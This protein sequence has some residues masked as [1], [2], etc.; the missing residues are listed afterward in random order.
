[1]TG[2]PAT[3]NGIV[4]VTASDSTLYALRE[5]SGAKIWSFHVNG[6]FGLGYG[7]PVITQGR[8]FI[9][10]GDGALY[11]LSASSGSKIWSFAAGDA[12]SSPTIGQ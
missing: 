8:L 2:T 10:A 9:G 5:S 12:L 3:S 11:A 6:G 7:W 1:M 4:Y